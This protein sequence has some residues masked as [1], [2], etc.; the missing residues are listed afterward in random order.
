MV[1]VVLVLVNKSAYLARNA[2]RD[3]HSKTNQVPLT[4]LGKAPALQ[5]VQCLL[6]LTNP[7]TATS[8]NRQLVTT[9]AK[10]Q[11][12]LQVTTRDSQLTVAPVRTVPLK[13]ASICVLDDTRSWCSLQ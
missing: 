10:L 11:K 1:V 12:A 8:D 2:A 7:S 3:A 4:Q 9:K 13:P 6:A 5:N